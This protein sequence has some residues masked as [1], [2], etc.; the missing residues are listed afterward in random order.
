[1]EY[2][3]FFDTKPLIHEE[4]PDT[5]PDAES[6]AEIHREDIECDPVRIYLREMG[7]VPLLTKEGEREIAIRIENARINITRIIFSI[8]FTLK[9]IIELG[10]L[11]QKGQAP[12]EDIIQIDE[13]EIENNIIRKKEEFY[14]IS[15]EIKNLLDKRRSYL[16]SLNSDGKMSDSKLAHSLEHNRKRI[17]N[18]IEKLHLKEDV[19]L[20][21]ADELQKT[22]ANIRSLKRKYNYVKK[23]LSDAGIDI[24]SINGGNIPSN[25]AGN[26]M[27]SFQKYIELN[28]MIKSSQ[29]RMGMRIEDIREAELSLRKANRE[30]E[31][32]KSTLIEANLRLVI[33]IAKRYIG[34]GMSFP[35]LIQEGNIGLMRAV[36]KFE[37]RRGYKFSTYATWWIRQAITRS[38]ADQS[39]TIRIPVHM[40]ETINKITRG[41]REIVQETGREPT[42]DEI[43][44]RVNLPAE[45]IKSILRIT[46]EPISLE[47]PIGDEGEDNCLRDFIEDKTSDSP[48]ESAIK[49]NLKEHIEKILS[50]LSPK[51]EQ[52]I[53]KRFGIGEKRPLTLEEVGQAFNVTRERIRQI[54]VKALRKL[55]HPSRNRWLKEFLDKT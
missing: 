4:N 37:Y 42:N 22:S 2:Y 52:V 41:M 26:I 51:E 44:K 6:A 28:S 14:S 9:K 8:P 20:A 3:D 55:K 48:L 27:N 45:K 7:G 53:R 21:F 38:I 43:A 40:V 30:W 36:D 11:V 25:P 16:K 5:D 33:S 24:D 23:K 47:T 13:F 50:S 32:A 29:R 39:R 1:M 10:R 12:L 35:D 18:C 31:L 54:E 49:E 34:K 19:T 46:K 17:F 15:L